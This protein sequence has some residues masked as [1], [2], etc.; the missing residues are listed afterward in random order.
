MNCLYYDNN[1]RRIIMS[2]LTKTVKKLAERQSLK[3]EEIVTNFMGG[4]S[5]KLDP[6]ETLKIVSASA[7][8]GEASY[9]RRGGLYGNATDAIEIIE[10][11]YESSVGGQYI[12]VY[13][14]IKDYRRHVNPKVNVFCI[15]TAGYNNVLVPQMS[16]R[17]AILTGWT[18][19]EI[20]FASEYI[21]QWDEIESRRNIN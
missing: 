2:R 3:P 10:R 7:I 13:K 1:K 12:N 9:Y 15:Q 19:K 5:Y 20:L 18:G 8:F 4:E 21:R 6:I 16:Y 14:L 17:C 11:G